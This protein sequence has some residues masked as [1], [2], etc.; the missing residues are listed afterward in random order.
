[1]MMNDE[2]LNKEAD[3]GKSESAFYILFAIQLILIAI[4]MFMPIQM[5]LTTLPL[6]TLLAIITLI[7]CNSR[8]LNK[9]QG[10]NIMVHLFICLGIFCTLEMF[11]NNHVQSAWNIAIT[12]YF[13]YPT[14]C[15]FLVPIAIRNYKGVEILL[16]IWS[17]FVLM[18]SFK[19]YWQ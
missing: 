2:E 15:A 8:Q 5:G 12:H 3:S 1:M 11:N 13:F 17:L 18:A 14:V 10:N 6:F 9:R 7:R 19:G 4:G 16:I